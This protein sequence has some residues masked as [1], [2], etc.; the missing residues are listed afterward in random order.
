MSAFP[1]AS[2]NPTATW[3]YVRGR[4]QL[5][6]YGFEARSALV[7]KWRQDLAHSADPMP[8]IQALGSAKVGGGLCVV[9]VVDA[10]G[11]FSWTEYALKDSGQRRPARGPYC[12]NHH[13]A[14]VRETVAIRV[15]NRARIA[16]V[17]VRHEQLRVIERCPTVKHAL[18]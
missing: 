7:F 16:R 5:A 10:Y 2:A 12:G 17:T 1:H 18:V 4:S 14:I 3:S 11:P 6:A 9:D 15:R 8:N 13:H